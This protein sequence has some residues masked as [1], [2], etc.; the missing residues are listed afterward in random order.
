MNPSILLYG[1]TVLCLCMGLVDG[2]I[3]GGHSDIPIA[4][5]LNNNYR[6][7]VGSAHL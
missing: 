7:S 2:D 6:N 3:I 4:I 5:G 1:K